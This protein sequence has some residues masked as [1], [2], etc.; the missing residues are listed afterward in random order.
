M[1][2]DQ[3]RYR[4]RKHSEGKSTASPLQEAPSHHDTVDEIETISI[5]NP[6]SAPG[7][8]I[9]SNRQD[10][11]DGGAQGAIPLGHGPGRRS[12]RS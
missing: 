2:H 7:G 12:W 1:S 9:D 4:S 10:H 6:G 5:S 3:Q 8:A 11:Q